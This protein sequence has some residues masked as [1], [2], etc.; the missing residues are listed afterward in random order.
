M[1]SFQLIENF[2]V[3]KRKNWK[4]SSNLSLTGFPSLIYVGK[5]QSYT[6]TGYKLTWETWTCAFPF[7]QFTYSWS[8]RKTQ[9]GITPVGKATGTLEFRTFLLQNDIVKKLS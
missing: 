7:F 5:K 6:C 4:K 2:C 1:N 8:A 3:E 9:Q